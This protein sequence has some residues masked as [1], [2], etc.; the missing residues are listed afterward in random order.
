MQKYTYDP[1]KISTAAL[2]RNKNMVERLRWMVIMLDCGRTD[3][4]V[5]VAN[6]LIA[7]LAEQDA[8]LRTLRDV[9]TNGVVRDVLDEDEKL[10]FVYVTK[11]KCSRDGC[12]K[13]LR[14]PLHW[15]GTDKVSGGFVCSHLLDDCGGGGATQHTEGWGLDG[16]PDCDTAG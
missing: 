15:N 9:A 13:P 3:E 14:F 12:D 16:E 6:G 8:T 5:E 1:S 11:Y 2:N 10:P 7:G 4:A